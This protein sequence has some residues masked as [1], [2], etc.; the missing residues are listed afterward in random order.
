VSA[1]FDLD[2]AIEVAVQTYKGRIDLGGNAYIHHPLRVMERMP[3]GYTKALAV[4]HDVAEFIIDGLISSG[5]CVGS[6]A[7]EQA[8]AS[9][10]VRG[11]P[12]EFLDDLRLL[13]RLPGESYMAYCARAGSKPATRMVKI[14]DI[15]DNMDTKRLRV[16]GRSDL[17]RNAK[18]AKALRRLLELDVRSC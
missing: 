2:L 12:K 1:S 11:F 13:T 4:M 9:L 17:Q 10:A 18:Y 3:D 14:A 5:Q 15:E 8:F 7:V 6:S 16:V